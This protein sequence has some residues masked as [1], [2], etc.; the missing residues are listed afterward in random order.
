M[1]QSETEK[2]FL[3]NKKLIVL[4]GGTAGWLTALYLNKVF[5]QYETTL[6]ESKQIGI[7]GVGEATTAR[8]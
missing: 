8:R 7:I 2:E 6:I 4:G 1:K 3:K 5:P